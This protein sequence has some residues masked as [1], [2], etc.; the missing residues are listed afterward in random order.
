MSDALLKATLLCAGN[1]KL[2]AKLPPGYVCRDV[3]G[4]H[5]EQK[6]VFMEFGRHRVKLGIGA[7]QFR[8]AEENGKFFL[9]ENEKKVT[10]ISFLKPVF[11]APEMAFFNLLDWC[12]YNCSFCNLPYGSKHVVCVEKYVELMRRKAGEIRSIAVTSGVGENDVDVKLMKAFVEAARKE[13][14]MPIGVEPFVS[15]KKQ[16]EEL[17]EAGATEIK[18]NIHSFD[19][20][21]LEREC[22]V[23]LRDTLSLLE[24]AVKVF[25]EGK[26]T[27][28]VLVGLGESQEGLLDGIEKLAFMGV[29]PNLRLVRGRG[30]ISPLS[31]LQM[32]EAQKKILIKSGLKPDM[33]TMCLRCKSCDIVPEWDL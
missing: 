29:I 32:A 25:G 22:P 5:G 33:E 14:S 28:N 20:H 11:H 1:V 23:F 6:T 24:H 19:K 10:A 4:P 2:E 21:V 27:T 15:Q 7:S 30:S 16:I 26:V 8:V 3:A 13:F 31:L 9:F 18:I 12:Q 17:H